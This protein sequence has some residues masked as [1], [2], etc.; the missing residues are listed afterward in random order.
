MSGTD[1]SGEVEPGGIDPGGIEPGGIEPGGPTTDALHPEDATLLARLRRVVEVVDPLPGDLLESGRA[2]FRLHRPGVDLMTM[3][4]APEDDAGSGPDHAA[5]DGRGAGL[6]AVRGAATSHLHF[7][8]LGSVTLDVEV[9]VRAGFA[10]VVGVVTD[11]AGA[12]VSVTLQTPSATFTTEPDGDGRFEVARVPVALMR[13]TLER[14]EDRPVA[15][16]WFETSS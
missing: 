13:L 3:L 6:A 10:E 5:H 11:T 4:T 9:T 2:L 14:G 16:P 8:E 15:T 1:H 7:F 12:V